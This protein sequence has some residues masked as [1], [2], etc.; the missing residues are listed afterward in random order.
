MSRTK[1]KVPYWCYL[2][3]DPEMICRWGRD[4]NRHEFFDRTS[5]RWAVKRQAKRQLLRLFRRKLRRELWRD[6]R[7]RI[8][9]CII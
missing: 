1:R 8:Q 5:F 4:H 2:C 9:E 7:D 6:L 3:D